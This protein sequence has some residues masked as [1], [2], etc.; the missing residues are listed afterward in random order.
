VS[1]KR[2]LNNVEIWGRRD[3]DGHTRVYERASSFRQYFRRKSSGGVNYFYRPAITSL[4]L[5]PMVSLFGFS[6]IQCVK[7]RSCQS[8]NFR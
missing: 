8:W 5:F 6:E 7:L 4:V 2:E 3:F 1:R